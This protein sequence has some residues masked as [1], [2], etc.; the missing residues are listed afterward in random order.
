[1][2]KNI[3]PINRDRHAKKKLKS[4]SNFVFAGELHLVGVDV[5]EF[6][7]AAANYPIVFLEDRGDADGFRPVALLGLQVGQNLFVGNEG[8]WNAPYI[9]AMI[10][11]Y[12]FALSRTGEPDIFSICVDENSELIS[13]SEGAALFGDS[14][15]PTEVIEEVKAFLSELHKMDVITREFCKYMAELNMFTPLNMRVSAS[16]T[17]RDI[18]GCYVFNEDRLNNLSQERYLELREKRYLTAVYAQLISL[19]QIDRLVMQHTGSKLPISL[20]TRQAL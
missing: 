3:V 4:V 15:E 16:S 10:R 17:V 2:F 6:V 5:S 7:R 19:S 8:K 12:P 20:D 18:T 14:G 13:E 9:P 11:R 1:M